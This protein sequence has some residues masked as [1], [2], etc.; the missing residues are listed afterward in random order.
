[1]QEIRWEFYPQVAQQELARAWLTMQRNLQLAST[2]I[3]TYGRNLNDYLV[4]CFKHNL[5]PETMTRESLA[6]YARIWP[7]GPIPEERI[8]SRLALDMVSLV[9]P[10]CSVLLSFVSTMIISLRS[11]F[12]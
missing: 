4:F 9:P 3:D 6:L 10:R 2:A 8:C 12:V 5:L 11:R 7:H 1:M